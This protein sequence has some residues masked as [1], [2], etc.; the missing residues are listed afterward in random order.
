MELVEKMSKFNLHTKK[1]LNEME[2]FC[3]NSCMCTRIEEQ[4]KFI[5]NDT[6]IY[7]VQFNDDE[8]KL[9]EVTE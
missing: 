4:E 2:I 9:V 5:V 6:N 3:D 8:M 1:C 7:F